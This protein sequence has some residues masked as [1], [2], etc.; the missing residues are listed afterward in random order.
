[1]YFDDIFS[2]Y[3]SGYKSSYGCQDVL[4]HSQGSSMNPFIFN[5][6][7]NDL[8]LLLEKKGHVFSYADDT[9]ILRKHRDY[10]SAYMICYQRLAQ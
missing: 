10:D 9:G 4:L 7:S 5:M 2:Q 3:L 6:F 8:L 1:M